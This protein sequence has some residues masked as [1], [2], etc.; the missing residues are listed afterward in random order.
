M[1]L[2]KIS[3]IDAVLEHMRQHRDDFRRCI[4]GFSGGKDSLLLLRL[5][6]RAFGERPPLYYASCPGCEWPEHL[7]FVRSFGAS[8]VDSGHDWD[9][10]DANPWAFLHRESKM[11]NKWGRIHQRATMRKLAK[12]MGKVLLWGNRTADGNQVQR[13]RYRG[14][15]GAELWMPLRD[16]PNQTVHDVLEPG[17]WSPVYQIPSCGRTGY[18]PG[19]IRRT[20]PEQRREDARGRLS[21]ANFRRFERLWR[22]HVATE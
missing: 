10:F 11:S 15:E 1:T 2:E 14:P 21:A 18:A 19:M 9:W 5:I 4:F 13:H 22:A 16:V 12:S 20:T 3:S 6:E 8:I 17:D 7:E